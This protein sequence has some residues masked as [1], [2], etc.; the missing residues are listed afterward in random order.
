MARGLGEAGC[1]RKWEGLG[2]G[3]IWGAKVDQGS[4]GE[5]RGLRKTK[6]AEEN[7]EF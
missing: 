1:W 6:G 2:P 3:E 4:L 5:L 7:H